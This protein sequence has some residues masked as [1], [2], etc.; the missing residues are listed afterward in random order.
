MFN[1]AVDWDIIGFGFRIGDGYFSFGASQHI[2]S[3]NALPSDL[4]RIIE[5]GFPDNT[6]LDF[7]PMRTQTTGYMQF[8][9]GYSHKIGDRLTVGVNVKPLMG[10]AAY[11]T[12]IKKFNLNTSELQWDVNVKGNVY[13]SAPVEVTMKEDDGNK[14]DNIEFRDF[15]DY[16]VRDWIKYG[17]GFNN[18]GIAFDLGAAFQIDERLTVSASLNNLGFISWKNKE[19]LNS[20]S[21][22]GNYTFDG[23]HHDIS[24]DDDVDTILENLLDELADA[25][26][27][28]VQN[29]KFKTPLAPAFHAGASYSL[30]RSVSAGFLSRTVFW[31]NAVRQSFNLSA[32]FQ[33]FSFVSFN[34]GITYQV[35]G[36]AYL[37]G[38]LMF[39]LGP[40]PLQ[41]YILTDYL[42]VY[43][44]TIQIGSDSD[45]RIPF[46]ERQKSITIRTGLN[47]VFGRHGYTNRPM[48]DKGKSSW[49]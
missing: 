20:V 38:G 28:H 5:N 45:V 41:F 32:Y 43:Y 17:M 34:A 10:Q 49:N 35:K 31:K 47:F 40:L 48:L 23:L 12:K 22:N 33:P 39:Y 18:P 7:S 44:S 9:F 29:D 3:I 21:F 19:D 46:P 2:S 30:S 27:Y 15:S 16:E 42:P 4:F 26:D 14:V 13:S 25:V 36:N 6:K 11:T 8:L 24:T 37:G 1:G